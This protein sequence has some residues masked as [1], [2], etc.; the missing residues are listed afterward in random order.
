MYNVTYMQVFNAWFVKPLVVYHDIQKQLLFSDKGL[1]SAQ[2]QEH[3]FD[4]HTILFYEQIEFT[5]RFIIHKAI[6]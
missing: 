1:V 6:H 2:Q 5:K 3:N 4:K